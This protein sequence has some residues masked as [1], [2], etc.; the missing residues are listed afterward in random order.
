VTQTLQY[1]LERERDLLRRWSRLLQR[2]LPTRERSDP[3][4][5]SPLPLPLGAGAVGLIS[6]NTAQPFSPH[7]ATAKG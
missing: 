2:T 4:R 6:P 3:R 5:G 7:I 1:P